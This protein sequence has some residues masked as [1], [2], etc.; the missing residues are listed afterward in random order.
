VN[1]INDGGPVTGNLY[2]LIN[3]GSASTTA[4]FTAVAHSNKLGIF[5]DTE[6]GGAYEGGNGGSF[7]HFKLPNSCIAV[8]ACF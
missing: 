5:I 4:E 3:G 6:T 1:E 8:G 2:F 7:L